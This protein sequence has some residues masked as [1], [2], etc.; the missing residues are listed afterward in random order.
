[1]VSSNSMSRRTR[2]GNLKVVMEV[3]NYDV[4]FSTMVEGLNGGVVRDD[5]EVGKELKNEF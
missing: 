4:Y 2:C 3:I 1:M 5:E